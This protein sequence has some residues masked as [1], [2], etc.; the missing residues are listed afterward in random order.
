VKAIADTGLIVGFINRTD[1]YHDWAVRLA[2]DITEPLLTCEAVLAEA[3]F[4]LQS[5]AIVLKLV[6]DGM[7]TPALDV[8]L[9]RPKTRPG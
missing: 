8:T 9:S 4:H 3:A 7:V 6:R 1:Q 2:R 5:S